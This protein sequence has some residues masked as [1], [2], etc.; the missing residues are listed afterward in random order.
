MN[1]TDQVT[2]DTTTARITRDG[3]LVADAFVART[4]IQTYRASELGMADRNPADVIRV[5]RSPDEVF[6]RD[7]M[8]SLAHKPIT[9]DHPSE[10]V[11]ADNWSRYAKGD[12][13]DEIARDGNRIRVPIKMMDAAA[14]EDVRTSRRQFS[15]GYTCDLAWGE[16]K[17][18]EGEVYDARQTN[19]RVNHLAACVN[20]RGGPELRIIDERRETPNPTKDS[21]VTNKTIMFDGL[22]VAD[23]SPAAEAVIIKLQGQVADA[24]KAKDEALTANVK[25]TADAVVAT[26]KIA[27]LEKQV[28][29]AAITPAKMRDAAKAYA[30]T[31]AKAKKLGAT[32]T[33]AM[34]EAAIKKAVVSAKLGDAAKDYTD[35]HVAIAFDTLTAGLKLDEVKD[36]IAEVI[37]N[38]GG[39][40]ADAEALADAAY[41]KRNQA[42]ADA[43]KGK[44]AA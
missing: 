9:I 44:E 16:G 27:D 38:G 25:L 35:E 4:G 5:Y 7:A 18:P 8:A 37:S 34:D 20:A 40:V 13:G 36:P 12:I 15:L 17:T 23:V 33:D 24:V 6:A 41:R 29:D 31:V 14:I 21:P 2:I 1:L 3:Y 22:P 11:T 39:Q 28:T 10:M 43:W 32:V 42:L 30:L 19:I 26:A